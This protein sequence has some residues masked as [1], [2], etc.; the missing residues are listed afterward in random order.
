MWSDGALSASQG[1]VVMILGEAPGGVEMAQGK[2][3]V[4]RAGRLLDKML[5]A[6]ALGENDVHITNI[7]YW[8]PPGNRNPTPEEAQICR[9]FLDRQ[10]ELVAPEILLLLGRP[11]ANQ[12]LNTTQGIM[13]LR[14]KW[15]TFEAGGRSMRAMATLHPAYLLRTPVAK[16]MAW[17]DLLA[18]RATLNDENQTSVV[19]AWLTEPT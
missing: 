17:R 8:R 9:P 10:I 15:H 19:D 18:I 2:P 1:E 11:A 3:F 13:K 7:V 6:I 16:R 4:G 14:G 12:L 5:G